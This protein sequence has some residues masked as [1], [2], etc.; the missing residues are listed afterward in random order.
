MRAPSPA[1][2]ASIDELYHLTYAKARPPAIVAL[3]RK[4]GRTGEPLAI[5]RII[6]VTLDPRTEIAE[7]T[8]DAVLQLRRH[9]DVRDVPEFERVFRTMSYSLHT[10]MERWAKLTP[11]DIKTLAGL[12]AGPTLLQL[13][14]CH[15]SGFVR[16]EAI[17][18]SATCSDGSETAFLLLRANDWVEPVR[19][20]AEAAL[21]A[22]LTVEH[23]PDLLA[24]LP[25]I[26]AMHG[27]GRLGAG[28]ILDEIEALLRGSSALDGL[29]NAIDSPDRFVRRRGYRRLF[30][31]YR[32]GAS[33]PAGD[34][35]RGSPEAKE[36]VFVAA[37]RDPDPGIRAWAA[38]WIVNADHAVFGT[39]V[40]ELL[41]H[42]LGSIRF[43]TANRLLSSGSRLPWSALLLDPHAGVRA[44]AQTAALEAGKDPDSEYRARLAASQGRQLGLALVG[45]SETGGPADA[46]LVRGYLA[47]ARP[48][49]RRHALEALATFAVDDI[50]ELALAALLDESPSVARAGRDILV[51][52]IAR[53]RGE[54]VWSAFTRASAGKIAAL[55]VFWH[56]PVWDGLRNLVRALDTSDAA[57]GE[58]VRRYIERW[59]ARLQYRFVPAPPSLEAEIRAAIGTSKLPD[60]VRRKLVAVLD[61]PV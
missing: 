39:F 35:Y 15:P 29:R 38:R 24:V 48:V 12:R 57:F 18:R 60:S 2:F 4:I 56:L 1:T 58:R 9:L 47:N 55:D 11:G 49:V 16:E 30:E 51:A 22:R 5:P 59:F 13:A 44:I 34:P 43:A 19:A 42:R 7:A 32:L 54:D 40:D 8:G 6:A 61:V 21:R 37:M 23:V 10:G 31:R 3:L 46:A 27:W 53:V 14:M 25:I 52:H 28:K 26:D 20:L 17:R 50:V 41:R 33:V 36:H 45:L